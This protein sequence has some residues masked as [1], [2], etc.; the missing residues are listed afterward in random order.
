MF[1]SFA[2][3]VTVAHQAP[4]SMEFSR[5]EYWSRL[6]FPP[7]GDQ[8]CISC[9]GRWILYHCAI[10]P[11][12]YQ[13]PSKRVNPRPGVKN[14]HHPVF[15]SS[16]PHFQQQGPC[17]SLNTSSVSH[18][19]S[20]PLL[21]PLLMIL[22]HLGFLW[23]SCSFSPVKLCQYLQAELAPPSLI[24]ASSHFMVM[25]SYFPLNTIASLGTKSLFIYFAY[26][27]A[28][29]ILALPTFS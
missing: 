1:N 11:Q 3:P 27:F 23:S 9:A 20:W 4:L 24:R 12:G 8:S 5:Q 14:S 16:Q 6:P 15:P 7:Q 21:F 29:F 25:I 26:I 19:V 18:P 13:W 2:T 22:P 10:K 28:F 17:S